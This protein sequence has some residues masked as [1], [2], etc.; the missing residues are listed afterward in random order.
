MS[1]PLNSFYKQRSLYDFNGRI[2]Y[3]YRISKNT[4]LVGILTKTVMQFSQPQVCVRFLPL[5]VWCSIQ[6]IGLLRQANL[7]WQSYCL[8]PSPWIHIVD[9]WF[10]ACF[11]GVSSTVSSQLLVSPGSVS[12]VWSQL[13]SLPIYYY[14]TESESR[15]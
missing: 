11:T 4:F 13:V 5:L 3:K 8:Y 10:I 14:T 7:V 12:S 9:S 6:Q 15:T 2:W 1:P